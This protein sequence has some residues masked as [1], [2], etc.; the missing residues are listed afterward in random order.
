MENRMREFWLFIN[1]LRFLVLIAALVAADSLRGADATFYAVVKGQ[2]FNQTDAGPPVLGSGTPYRFNA[3]VGLAALNAV[4]NAT[5]QWLPAGPV[6]NLAAGT[7]AFEFQDKF[8][9]SG[10]LNTAY[11]DGN[12]QV[13][14]DA[15]HD[16]KQ[17]PT[18]S[19][20]GNAY[21][22]AA[23]H[24]T[25]FANAQAVNPGIPFTLTWDALSGGTTNDF[26]QL[27]VED[28]FETTISNRRRR[29]RPAPSTGSRLP[30]SF[31][32]AGCPR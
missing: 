24:V 15:F 5:V 6:H 7:D 22:S 8:A 31:P 28:N 11:P 32:R 1:R 26:V 4:T 17:P 9:S 27:Q 16:G 19:L 12:F 20:S 14:I 21:P 29:G 23:P 30:W 2:Q 10:E 18:L 3:I 25:D 13:V